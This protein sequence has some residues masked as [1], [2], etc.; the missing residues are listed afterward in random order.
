MYH[1]PTLPAPTTTL[2]PPRLS[3][4]FFGVVLIF[5]LRGERS[6]LFPWK[7]L[8]GGASEQ[9]HAVRI[10]SYKPPVS[11]A[12]G[13]LTP[14]SHAMLHAPSQVADDNRGPAG[15]RDESVLQREVR[16]A[17][18][19]LGWPPLVSRSW[20]PLPVPEGAG[21][22]GDGAGARCDGETGGEG[23]GAG[24]AGKRLRVLSWN[25]LC[26]GLSGAH[27]ARGGF[28]KAPEGSLDWDKRRYEE[29]KR[30]SLHT[31][32]KMT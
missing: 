15:A 10:H 26:D 17:V 11:C 19:T 6:L 18:E 13:W 25:V 31:Y 21:Q 12:Q 3:C 28:L 8:R 27:P 9:S 24:G 23:A 20:A 5:P 30:T 14:R 22:A 4:S 29:F 2:A 7:W 32:R 1:L 16:A